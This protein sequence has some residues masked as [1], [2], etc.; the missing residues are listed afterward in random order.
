MN[1]RKIRK[2]LSRYNGVTQFT[3]RLVNLTFLI[4]FA[5]FS[6]G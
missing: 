5:S 3:S 2:L 1:E 4:S 6:N